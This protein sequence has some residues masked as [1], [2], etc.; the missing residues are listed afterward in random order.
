MER[1]GVARTAKDIVVAGIF[2]GKEGLL[3]ENLGNAKFIMFTNTLLCF[4]KSL[5]NLSNRAKQTLMCGV[6]IHSCRF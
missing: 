3:P 2:V 4:E 6:K 5:W 1:R